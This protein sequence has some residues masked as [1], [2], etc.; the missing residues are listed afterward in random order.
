MTFPLLGK[1]TENLL[2]SYKI[3]I[4]K[5]RKNSYIHKDKDKRHMLKVKHHRIIKL[6]T[7]GAKSQCISTSFCS[8]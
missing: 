5:M 2:L 8:V 1:N 4:L 7:C 3:F 6:F